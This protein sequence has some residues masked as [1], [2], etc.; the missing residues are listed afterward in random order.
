M[1]VVVVVVVVEALNV[2]LVAVAVVEELNVPL[3]AVA[4]AEEL[5]VPLLVVVVVEEELNVPL[6]AV[7]AVAVE[8]EHLNGLC[9]MTVEE[10]GVGVDHLTSI[11][12]VTEV[13]VAEQLHCH[14]I[15]EA[16]VE[17]EAV[18]VVEVQ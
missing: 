1:V 2:P 12:V 5:N 4:V 7:A 3:V 13:A 6:V 15:L 18:V 9:W 11:L 8:E 16:V 10:V 17:V 14:M